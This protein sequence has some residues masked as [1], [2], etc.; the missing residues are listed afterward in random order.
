M[1]KQ[2][3]P[4]PS[5]SGRLAGGKFAPGN[6]LSNGRKVGSRNKASIVAEQM[7]DAEGELIVRTAIEMAKS[8]DAAALKIVMDRLL[9]PRR[10]RHV[11]ITLP[12]IKSSLDAAAAMAGVINEVS[13][14]N[15]TLSEA[16]AVSKLIGDYS[17]ILEISQLEERINALEKAGK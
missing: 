1:A 5:N 15:I 14:A 8:G 11:S 10:D 4:G 12:E 9:P 3:D 16:E 7:I 6:K 17:K 13:S 2:N